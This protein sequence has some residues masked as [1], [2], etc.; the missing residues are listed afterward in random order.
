MV[1]F[2][3][4]GNTL[5]N[6]ENQQLSRE[7]PDLEYKLSPRNA[8]EF[9]MTQKLNNSTFAN[10]LLERGMIYSFEGDTGSYKSTSA[11]SFLVN[12][13]LL[14]KNY[15]LFPKK[16]IVLKSNFPHIHDRFLEIAEEMNKGI[17]FNW[18]NVQYTNESLNDR[19]TKTEHAVDFFMRDENTRDWG[20]GSRISAWAMKNNIEQKARKRD[21]LICFCSKNADNIPHHYRL[22]SYEPGK[23]YKDNPKN[24]GE[25]IGDCS[26]FLVFRHKARKQMLLGYYV[27]FRLPK[28]IEDQYLEHCKNKR[29]GLDGKEKGTLSENE[30]KNTYINIVEKLWNNNEIRADLRLLEKKEISKGAFESDLFSY[31]PRTLTKTMLTNISHYLQKCHKIGEFEKWKELITKAN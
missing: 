3:W 4:T 8:R 14:I 2:V 24:G 1:F 27:A 20:D 11:L 10:L 30:R 31:A 25:F 7:Y 9:N 16:M 13:R 17:W 28:E 26:R 18:N 15:T 19:L 6:H 29:V 12:Q 21:W 23:M 5:E 22:Q